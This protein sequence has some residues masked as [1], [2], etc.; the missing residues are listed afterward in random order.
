MSTPG[1]IAADPIGS[2]RAIPP[3]PPILAE[4]TTLATESG[5]TLAQI[6]AVMGRDQGLAAKILR[7]INSVSQEGQEPVTGLEQALAR[8]GFKAVRSIA[9]SL[10]VIALFRG[11]PARLG[12]KG[13]WFHG[14]L[15]ATMCRTVAV[16]GR[17][18]AAETAFCFGLLKDIGK[19]LLAGSLPQETRAIIAL[20]DAERLPFREAARKVIGTDDAGIAAWFCEQWRLDA[21]LVDAVRFQNDFTHGSPCLTAAGRLVE[22]LCSLR[23]IRGF[24]SCHE[25]KLDPV[26]WSHL[27][28]DKDA[29]R[30]VI[31]AMDRDMGAT[32]ELLRIAS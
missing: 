32:R 29:L 11:E 28:L 1:T 5:T 7:V 16:L 19:L 2:I 8:L 14:A 9:L 13:F 25:S 3:I 22:H 12:M 27:G 31:D 18:C 30:S 10:S 24:G 6:A 17:V 26:V 20:A 23:A 15:T 21:P 4:V